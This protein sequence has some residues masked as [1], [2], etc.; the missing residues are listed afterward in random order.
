[1]GTQGTV[2]C[3]PCR[4]EM[5]VHNYRV[6]QP[7]KG[8][9]NRKNFLKTRESRSPPG[10]LFSR[11]SENRPLIGLIDLIDQADKYMTKHFL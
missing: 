10:R 5:G 8:D 6:K 4:A 11:Q 2:L 3:V 7:P 1:M 9:R